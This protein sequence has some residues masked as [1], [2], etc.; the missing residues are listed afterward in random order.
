MEKIISNWPVEG[1]NFIDISDCLLYPVEN[2]LAFLEM[3]KQLKFD[4]NY[5]IISPESRGFIFGAPLAQIVKAPFL[6]LRKKG[7]LPVSET[8]SQFTFK[9]PN[10][11]AIA[12]FVLNASSL[13]NLR[14]RRINQFIIVDDILATGDTALAISTFLREQGFSVN[15]ALFYGEIIALKA[16]DKLKVENIQCFSFKKY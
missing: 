9:A 11:Y 15:K 5:A 10:E 8:D 3:A 7:K 14:S 4:H 1:V 12:E 2:D 13:N 6:M 16:A